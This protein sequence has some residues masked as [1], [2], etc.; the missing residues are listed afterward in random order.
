MNNS[1]TEWLSSYESSNYGTLFYSLVKIYQPKIVVELGTK[2]GYSAYHIAKG[3]KENNNG[4][5]YC[6]DLWEKYP[7]NTVTMF[8]AEENLKEFKDIVTL[9]QKDATKIDKDYMSIDILHVDLS[10]DGEI[11]EKIIP[12]WLNKVNQLI[13]L[14]G[15]SHIRDQAGWMIKY[16][17]TP[18]SKWLSNLKKIKDIQYITFDKFPSLTIIQTKQENKDET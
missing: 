5:L 4:H 7:Y 3:L 13:I 8:D 6:Y 11:L 16:C 12:N 17:K 9:Q 10:N 18:I 14:E 2:A 1:T 15:G